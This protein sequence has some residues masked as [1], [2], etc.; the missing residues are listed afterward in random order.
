MKKN[1]GKSENELKPIHILVIDDD[2]IFRA[3]MAKAATAT[4]Y[5]VTLA[6]SLK[7]VNPMAVPN[8]FDVVVVDYYLDNI[9]ENLK[10]T[11]LGFALEGTPILL[12]SASDH[13]LSENTPWPP[14]VRK[15]VSKKSGA[16]SILNEAHKL[17]SPAR[18]AA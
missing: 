14:S 11:D 3:L 4:N 16:S 17:V 13:A 12:M 6:S 10:G 18:A 8:L 9:Q 7:E 15:F 5:S 2:P 1:I